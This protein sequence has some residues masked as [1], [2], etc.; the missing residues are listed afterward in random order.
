MIWLS[1]LAFF[2][3]RVRRWWFSNGKN[4]AMSKARVLF[5]RFMT[6]PVQMICVSAIPTSVMNLNFKP[7][8]WLEWIKSLAAIVNWSLSPITF[9][10]SLPT[11]LSR[12]IGLKDFGKSYDVLFG[13]GMMTVVNLLKYNSVKIKEGRL[14][15]FYF[16]L[17]FNFIFDLFFYFIF[18]EQLGLG[19]ISHTITSVTWWQSHKTD[20]KTWKN[21]VQDSRTDDVIQHGHHMLAS[22]TTHGCLG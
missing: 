4:C 6:Q 13:L 5:D 10:I 16:S 3:M 15:L 21:L 22:W 20:H 8:S 9:S 14:D 7:L 2:M 12:T 11:V 17:Y 18:L 1:K 19:L